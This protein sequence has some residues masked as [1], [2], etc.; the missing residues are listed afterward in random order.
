[1]TNEEKLRANAQLVVDMLGPH[2]HD[3]AFGFNRA[4]LVWVQGFIERQRVR[5]D[6]DAEFREGMIQNVGSYLG[7]CIIAC[8]GGCWSSTPDGWA[9]SFGPKRA[10]F[11]FSKVRKQWDDGTEAGES[12]VSFFDTIPILFPLAGRPVGIPSA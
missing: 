5:P 4:S 8:H 10:A 1:M 3:P 9:I 2:S 11:P 7:E 6:R 12:I